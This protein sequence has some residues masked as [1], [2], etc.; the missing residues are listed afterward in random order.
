MV[1]EGAASISVNISDH[2]RQLSS[3]TQMWHAWYNIEVGT[4]GGPVVYPGCG[5]HGMLRI[6]QH[7][8]C[9]HTT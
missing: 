9:E 3:A 2:Q 5:T 4:P 7:D 8:V 6:A 1:D